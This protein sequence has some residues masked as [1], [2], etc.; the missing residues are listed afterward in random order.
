MAAFSKELLDPKECVM[1]IIDHQ[2]QMFFGVEST[3]RTAVMNN[4]VGLAK[5]MKVFEVPVI[6]STIEAKTF[7]GPLY[8][9]LQNVFP[10]LVPIDRTN[11]NAW[12]DKNV[13]KEVE[14]T[15]RKKLIIAGLWTE[16][17]VCFPALCAKSDGFDVYAVT[18]ASAGAT[19]EAHDMAIQRMI[20]AQVKP[21]TWAQ[22]L[23][24]FQRDWS[25]KKTYQQVMD[26]IKT[27]AGAYGLGVEYA[28]AM[29]PQ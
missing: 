3:Q 22:V 10:D 4:I 19:K 14:K 9:A 27:H 5:A 8:C 12:E 18:D 11:I 24:E 7:S 17:C 2:P 23:L 1:L 21:L 28:E 6:F 15:K 13:L 16:A 25:H 26:I 20:G 29:L